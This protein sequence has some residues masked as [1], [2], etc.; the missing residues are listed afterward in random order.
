MFEDVTNHFLTEGSMGRQ[1][2]YGLRL[3]RWCEFLGC[4]IGSEQAEYRILHAR[5]PDA[6]RF[7]EIQ[8]RRPGRDGRTGQHGMATATLKV[9]VAALHSYYTRLVAHGF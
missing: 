4:Q 1:R 3:R 2:S 6:R 8:E 9:T 5:P 7:M